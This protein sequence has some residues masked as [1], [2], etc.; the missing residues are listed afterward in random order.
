MPQ[1]CEVLIIGIGFA[2]LCMGAKLKNGGQNNFIFLEKAAQLGGTWRDNIYPG[3][4]C[5]VP[6]ALYSFSFFPNPTWDFKWAHQ[7]QIL[8][9]MKAFAT[10]FQLIPHMHFRQNAT[11]A[12]YDET[13][14]LWRVRTEQGRLYESHFLVSAV[15]QL[16]H[17]HMPDIPGLNQFSGACFHSA[18]WNH[19]VDLK[20]QS[21]A[22]IGNAASA[23]QLIPKLAEH[24]RTLTIYQRSANWIMPKNARAYSRAEQ[25]VAQYIPTLALLYR[26]GL[27][28]LGEF[29]L[30]PVIK[31]RK[32]FSW[33]AKT[34]C[35]RHIRRHISNR[36]LQKT[37]VPDYP[38]GAKRILF[39]DKYY[40]TLIRKNVQLVTTPIARVKTDAIETT[41]QINRTHSVIICATGFYSHPFLKH[42]KVTNAHGQSL[43]EHWKHGAFAYLS[44]I[45]HTFPNLFFLY[46]P[47]SNT[48]HTSILFKIERQVDL[49]LKLMARAGRD[50]IAIRAD[51]EIKFN[52]S[53]QAALR[54]RAWQNVT[55]SWYKDGDKITNNWPWSSLRFWWALSHPHWQHFIIHQE[56]VSAED[57]AHILQTR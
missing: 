55:T 20:D 34:Q 2:G 5:D 31:N 7:P 57:K 21:V 43:A 9:Y 6:S 46:G 30:W 53:V 4:E 50:D 39:S 19:E 26:L 47:N 37:L 3:A 54:K 36:S 32:P 15:G 16:H 40:P 10:H 28:C 17:P 25:K 11:H 41:D 8:A 27:W 45:T 33:L 18:R 29:Y 12:D 14:K 56:N 22:V 42:I 13:R 24:A 1:T 48:G 49:C 38:I 51:S 23:I 44:V 35:I 52:R